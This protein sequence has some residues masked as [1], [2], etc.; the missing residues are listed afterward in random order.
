MLEAWHFVAG[1]LRDGRPVPPDG[2]LLRHEG[3][4]SPCAEG[5]H[6]SRRIID[7]LLYASGP[8]CCRVLVGGEIIEGHDKLV[9]SERT[10]LWRVDATDVLRK[11]ARECALDVVH[12]WDAPDVVRRYLTTGDESLSDTARAA[13]LGAPMYDAAR[14]AARAAAA[15]IGAER[16]AAWAAERAAAA[17][18]WDTARDTQNKR[19]ELAVTGL[20]DVSAIGSTCA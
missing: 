1:T 18:A 6:A 3:K 4:L 16:A 8:V 12:L 10:I 5:L 7:A 11:F 9:A 17:A 13:A 2:E 20:R 15:A 19:L 14:A